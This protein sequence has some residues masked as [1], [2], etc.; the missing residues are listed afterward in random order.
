MSIV[1]RFLLLLC[2]VE[3]LL[4]S[5][6]P[7]EASTGAETITVSPLL[8]RAGQTVTVSGTGWQEHGS[9]GIDVPIWIG[10]SGVSPE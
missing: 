4:T 9:R 8:G 6:V 2:A 1:A 5:L 7:A 3:L 10:H